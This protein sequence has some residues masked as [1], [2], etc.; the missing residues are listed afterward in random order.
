VRVVFDTNVVLSAL[1]FG[2][3]LAWLRGAWARRVVI[4]IECRETAADLL[5]VLAYPKFKLTATERD[6]LLA[7]Y[8]PFTEATRLPESV[9]VLPVECR[10]RDDAVFIRL[11][12]AAKAD[13]LVSGDSDLAVLQ[14]VVP[15]PIISANELQ[16][17]L[18]M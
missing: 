14:E 15:T 12:L 5:R 7:D 8:L 4:P 6:L 9:S 3:R 16:R 10:D 2:S 13:C 11:A 1:I 17:R 18:N